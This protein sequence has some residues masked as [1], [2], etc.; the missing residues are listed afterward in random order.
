MS[1]QYIAEVSTLILR[2]G[3]R[4]CGA[5]SQRRISAIRQAIDAINNG[6]TV[7]VVSTNQ[8]ESRRAITVEEIEV[9][10]Q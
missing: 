3:S 4:F 6:L 2:D 9:L 1:K 7:S 8:V 10:S 5:E